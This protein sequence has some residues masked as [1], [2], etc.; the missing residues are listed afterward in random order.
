M[1]RLVFWI[2][3]T[4]GAAVQ[5]LPLET[6]FRLGY[7]LGIVGYYMGWPY[8]KLVLVNLRIAFDGEKTR[9]EQKRIARAHFGSLVGNLFASL[10]LPGISP[11]E[12]ASVVEV[13]GLECINDV[14]EAERGF[15][16]VIGHIGNWELFAQ[17]T[18]RIFK[19]Q[20]GTIY[21]RLGNPFI[22]QDVRASR[23]RLG[24]ELFERKEGFQGAMRLLRAGGAVGVLVDQHAGDAGVW[25]PFFGRLASTSSL[26]ATLALRTGK[27]LLSAAVYTVAPGRWRM[28]LRN[29]AK[30][31]GTSDQITL[32]L[33][34]VL[35]GMVRENPPDWFWVHDRW[36]T[37]KPKFLLSTYKRGVVL[38]EDGV[39][40]KPFRI[41]I[42]SSNWL[43]DALMSVPAV[44]AIK[45]GRP[46][47][48]VTIL[49][50]SKLADV[51][52]EVAEVDAIVGIEPKDN[53]FAVAR[54][55]RG[56]DFDAAILFPNSLRVALE[57]W[58][59]GIPRRVGYP[60][61]R[62]SALLNQIPREKKKKQSAAPEHQVNHYLRL[63]EFI[64]AET[65]GVPLVEARP[66]F[67]RAKTARI[68]LCPGAEYGPAK[69][70][71]PERFGEV[72]QHVSA[73]Y[74]CAWVLVGVAKDLPIGE[75]ILQHAGSARVENLIGKTTL[76]E[77]I[78]F[79]RTCEL[80]LTNDTG[81]MHLAAFLGV[82][83]VAVFGSTEPALTGP[84]GEG[85]H[86]LRRHVA[87]SPCFLRECP[88]D[89]RCMHAVES[90]AV[91]AA[92]QQL[93]SSYRTHSVPSV[94]EPVRTLSQ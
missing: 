32:Q 8:R 7:A 88:L 59:A 43:G 35:E 94:S 2:Y 60:G 12:L 23:A 67:N 68:A 22:D 63:A 64:G 9:E 29:I 46:D 65:G 76:A 5:W 57:S 93:L 54:K 40:L 75:D 62:R 71:L 92:V 70:W 33:N 27:P 4:V 26:A 15:V 50:P 28:V 90:D 16:M 31:I 89:F 14:P 83:V 52:R 10:R 47:A 6:V 34:R 77:L 85:H 39:P 25:C 69:R 79:L 55:L 82:P 44:R 91:A 84:L 80:L 78:A 30:P 1:D 87:C 58:L 17:L 19:C 3:R 41:V 37:P 49:T 72:M 86:V 48:H 51:W 13:E 36:K 24:L 42:R 21:Q 73:E 18:P 20:T 74:D 11:E 38:P 66:P 56:G 45:R 81:T 61:H 53:V